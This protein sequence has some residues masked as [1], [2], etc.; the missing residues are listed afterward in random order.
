MMLL[1]IHWEHAMGM[2]YPY[3]LFMTLNFTR[4]FLHQ[5]KLCYYVTLPPIP[6][7]HPCLPM[8]VRMH[9]N[10]KLNTIEMQVKVSDF[11]G[12]KYEYVAWAKAYEQ[13]CFMEDDTAVVPGPEG[14]HHTNCRVS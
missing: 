5:C 2:Y 3:I 14:D 1:C 6:I 12:W 4:Y 11:V 9:D 7:L 10:G 8:L 13:L